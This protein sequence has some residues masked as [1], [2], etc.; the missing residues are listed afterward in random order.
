[1]IVALFEDE[2]YE[3]FL[4]I[5]YTRPVFECRG[6]MSS[7]LQRAQR[8]YPES[9]TI[10]FTRDYLVPTLKRRVPNHV[11]EPDSIDDETL[12]INGTLVVDE[13]VKQIIEKKLSKDVVIMQR[14]RM[15][16]ARLSERL[17]RKHGRELCS[18]LTRFTLRD[19]AKE[20]KTLEASNLPLMTYP[21]DLISMNAELIR[22]DYAALCKGECE[23]TLDERIAVYGEE[24]DVYVD[25]G[26]HIEAHVTL[27][28]RDGPIYIGKETTVHAGSRIS[29][30]A[31]IGNRTVIATGLIRGG[32]SIG[33]VCRVGGELEESIV[34]GYSNKYHTGFIGHAYIGEWVNIGAATTN[35]DLK[36]TYGT[37]QV[38]TKGEKVDTGQIK[39]GCFI[40]DHVKT[41]IGT[42]IYTGKKIG[43]ASQVYGF[44]AEDVPSFTIWAKSLGVQ[45]V[46]LYLESVIKTQERVM[47]RRG[48][49]QTT[50]DIDLLKK[51]FEITARERDEA[52][53]SKGKFEL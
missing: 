42:Q 40:A 23:G 45:P 10:L 28:A 35:S 36:N 1:M 6:G 46:E 16:L 39:V 29:G 14:E 18:P 19:I 15:A 8:M 13:N 21:W 53:V 31:Y 51:L 20:C 2:D 22:K 25:E 5:T 7:F 33:D 41:S 27:D 38:T 30:P 3:N 52:G 24:A 43:V 12:L 47:S 4:P 50:E 34:Q 32:C 44:V 37:V 49:K 48:V 17:A 26:S 11:N 9:T